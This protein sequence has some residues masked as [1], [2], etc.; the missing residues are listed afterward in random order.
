VTVP[1]LEKARPDRLGK[2][3]PPASSRD[4]DLG[5]GGK[6]SRP[7]HNGG[8]SHSATKRGRLHRIWRKARWPMVV[9][10]CV[11]IIARLCLPYAVERFVNKKLNQTKDYGGRINHVDIQLWRGQYRIH[12]ITIFKR[13]GA[14]KTPLFSASRVDLAIEWKELIHGSVVGEVLMYQPRVN[15]VSGPPSQDTM[16][17]KD[18]DWGKMLE[19][20]FPFKLNRFEIDRGEIHFQNPNSTPPVDIYLHQLAATATN[21]SNARDVHQELPAGIVA[22]GTT[23]GGGGLDLHVQLNPMEKLPTYQVTCALTNVDLAALN[24]FLKAYGK[25]DV[26]RGEFALFTSVASKDGNY[27]GYLKVFFKDLKVFEWEKEKKKN[28]LAII[29]QAIVGA[30]TATVKNHSTD[31]VATKVPISGT[32]QKSSVG[33]WTAITT[34]LQNGFIKALAPE[35]DQ[36]ETVKTIEKKT[37]ENPSQPAAQPEPATRKGDG[38]APKH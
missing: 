15:F 30:V 10:V 14:D 28:P 8:F 3:L 26:Q 20:L 13:S 21:L 1:G 27:E 2:G 29:W 19:S 5:E 23:L 33:V 9:L 24:S 16:N 11:L 17:S 25:F 32:Y 22:H 37:E 34:L 18:E 4:A 6:Y 12:E 7:A 38:D 36:P 35:L 31:S